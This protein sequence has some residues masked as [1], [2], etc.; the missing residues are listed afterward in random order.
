MYSLNSCFLSSSAWE[1]RTNIPVDGAPSFELLTSYRLH[2][3]FFSYSPLFR[4][5]SICISLFS[6]SSLSSACILISLCV[7][8]CFVFPWIFYIIHSFSYSFPS[9]WLPSP[10]WTPSLHYP[11]S[12]LFSFQL[13]TLPRI[14][15][16]LHLSLYLAVYQWH[17]IL[18]IT[19]HLFAI[20]CHSHNIASS[21]LPPL[22][23]LCAST[24]QGNLQLNW[25]DICWIYGAADWTYLF[26]CTSREATQGLRES[27]EL[28]FVF[29]FVFCRE[30]I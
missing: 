13:Q 28:F 1:L 27:R 16:F 20:C 30:G 8:V 18:K 2:T 25:L 11:L 15:P 26:W 21:V 19:L 14:F 5:S 22:A 6:L 3:D 12:G 23:C 17:A 9:S 24:K 7:H 4:S 10:V 29:C